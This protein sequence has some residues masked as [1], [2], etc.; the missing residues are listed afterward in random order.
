MLLDAGADVNS[1][2]NDIYASPAFHIHWV[3]GATLSPGRSTALIV[4]VRNGHKEIVSMLI[5]HGADV[6]L[7][8]SEGKTALAYAVD[9]KHAE[10][11]A[12]LRQAGAKK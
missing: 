5:K 9:E 11:E 3:G 10:I 8:D 7:A 4:A 12:M 2:M 1:A 6:N